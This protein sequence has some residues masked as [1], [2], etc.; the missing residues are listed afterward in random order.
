M[1]ECLKPTPGSPSRLTMLVSDL[2]AIAKNYLAQPIATLVFI[3]F[4][5]AAFGTFSYRFSRRIEGNFAF[6]SLFA[7]AVII[8][9]TIIEHPGQELSSTGLAM[10]WL[11]GV[12]QVAYE[13]TIRI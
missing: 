3:A 7:L 4:I 1:A 11:C 9:L 8:T 6:T 13:R 10:A 5:L 12:G 2:V